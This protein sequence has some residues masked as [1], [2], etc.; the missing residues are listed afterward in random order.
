[1]L[2]FKISELIGKVLVYL[3]FDEIYQH[4]RR[5]KINKTIKSLGSGIVLS[6]KLLLFSL[7]FTL[8][9]F[10]HV[11]VSMSVRKP[12]WNKFIIILFSILIVNHI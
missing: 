12:N 1:M 3:T 6:F 2:A 9:Q 8:T 7:V 10:Y 5:N 4:K 11:P